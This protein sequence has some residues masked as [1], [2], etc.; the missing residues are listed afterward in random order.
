M[1]PSEQH[2]RANISLGESIPSPIASVARISESPGRSFVRINTLAAFLVAIIFTVFCLQWSLMRGRLSQDSTYDD[3]AYLID[4]AQ[5]LGVFYESGAGAFVL[6]LAEHPPH[7]PFSTLGAALSFAVFGLH[8]WAP[9]AFNGIIVF[10][11]LCFIGYIAREHPLSVRLMAM[12]LGLTL[13]LSVVAI[14]DFRPDVACGLLTASAFFLVV[15]SVAFRSVAER[16]RGLLAGGT[17][18]GIALWVKPSFFAHTLAME[19]IAIAGGWT[20]AIVLNTERKNPWR[21]LSQIA[22]CVVLPCLMVAAPYYGINARH[23]L[24]YFIEHT[25]GEHGGVWKLPGGWAG[26]IEYYTLGGAGK[27]LL[28]EGFIVCLIAFFVAFGRTATLRCGKEIA[29]QGLLLAGVFASLGAMI[30]GRIANP[31]FGSSFQILLVFVVLRGV[32]FALSKI[33][34]AGRRIL[35]ACTALGLLSFVNVSFLRLTR[36]WDHYSPAVNALIGRGN[37]LNQR[38]VDDITAKLGVHASLVT[39]PPVIFSTVTGFINATSMEWLAIM[40]GRRLVTTDAQLDRD[41]EVFRR[42]ITSATFIVSADDGTEGVFQ[43]LPGWERRFD[44]AALITQEEHAGRLQL[45]RRYPTARGAYQLYV[46]NRWLLERYGAFDSFLSWEGFMPWEGP[47]PTAKLAQVRWSLAPRSRV[48]F[49]AVA[50]GPATLQLSVLAYHPAHATILLNG[51]QLPP[52][53]VTAMDGFQEFKLPANVKRGVN[54]LE[55]IYTSETVP[56]PDG[57]L[58]ALLFRQLEVE[59][60]GTP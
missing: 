6:D 34:S 23:A 10:A 42:K 2:S 16:R 32:L 21:L 26:S 17:I 45:V 55:F 31:F 33:E 29:F 19:A 24:G 8:D 27:A 35:F 3:C 41:L 37:S 14:H 30:Y 9:Y 50:A 48:T 46:N 7:S 39:E 56:G 51:S 22:L 58:R 13:P 1:P 38:I 44:I 53:N 36:V 28:G 60:T 57:Y 40:G 20:F 12:A 47:S 15:E 49:H 18:F 5:R 43:G 4:G 59:L 52:L 11:L 25:V 54:E